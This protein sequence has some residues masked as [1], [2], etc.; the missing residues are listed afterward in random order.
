MAVSIFI[1]DS[2][3]LQL[4]KSEITKETINYD[5]ML[6][7]TEYVKTLHASENKAWIWT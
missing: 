5:V 6:L 2:K 3:L 4:G 7:L 1:V